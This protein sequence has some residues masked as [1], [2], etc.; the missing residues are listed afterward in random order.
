MSSRATS[1]LSIAQVQRLTTSQY[2][3]NWLGRMVA[4]ANPM[5]VRRL[6]RSPTV[7]PQGFTAKAIMFHLRRRAIAECRH[8]FLA[9]FH[10]E[11]WASEHG[12]AFSGNCDHRFED[13]FLAKQQQDYQQ[14]ESVLE[15]FPCSQ[16]VELGA[17]SGLLLQHLTTNLPGIERAIGIDINQEQ[18]SRNVAADHFDPRIQFLCTDGQKWVTENSRPSTLYV[19]NGGV[20]EYFRREKLDRMISH[21]AEHSGP[22]V[23]YCSEP[24]ADDHDFNRQTDSIP[25]GDEFSFSHSYRDVFESNGFRILHQRAVHYESWRMQAT[26]AVTQD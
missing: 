21:I 20:L 18:I 7:S 12:A 22:S 6:F 26:I 4:T 2:V 16:I 13:L 11:F 3:K 24:V 15:Q 14:L 5:Q 9:R 10:K 25:F 1:T 23:F 17:N 19:T 8:G